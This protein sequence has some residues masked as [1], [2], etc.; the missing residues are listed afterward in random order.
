MLLD[1]DAALT[2]YVGT[3]KLAHFS[4]KEYFLK[5]ITSEQLSHSMIAQTCLAQLLYFD[6]PNILDWDRPG[7]A[8]DSNQSPSV[9]AGGREN[10]EI[11]RC[12]GRI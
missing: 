3:I 5:H 2:D 1:S 9:L 12:D 7:S 10:E 4:V 6:G 11:R 8:I